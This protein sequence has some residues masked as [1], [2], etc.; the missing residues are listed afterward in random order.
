MGGG[1]EVARQ[2]DQMLGSQ[3]CSKMGAGGMEPDGGE[4]PD[5]GRESGVR[6]ELG[7]RLGSQGIG[8]DGSRG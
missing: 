3:G 8:P 4:G 5:W 2:G 6:Q 7:A 1:L